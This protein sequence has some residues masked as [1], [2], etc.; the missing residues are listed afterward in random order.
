MDV[1]LRYRGEAQAHEIF[2][3]LKK[4]HM[5]TLPESSEC[6]GKMFQAATTNT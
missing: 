5:E 2:F 1:P 4:S 3:I 6:M